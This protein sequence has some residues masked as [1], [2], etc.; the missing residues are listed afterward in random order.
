MSAPGAPSQDDS[1]DV[2]LP[3]YALADW[4]LLQRA[5]TSVWAQ[6]SPAET[7]WVLVNGASPD[8]RQRLAERVFALVPHLIAASGRPPTI[9]VALL[10]Q[11]G[12]TP[13]LNHGLALSQAR[14]LARL[15]AD[16]RMAPE[17]L[18][19][20][21]DHLHRC[22]QA[23]SPVPDVIGSAMEVLDARGDHPTGQ[24]LQR[25]CRDRAIRRYLCVGNPFLH[26]SVML[27]RALLLQVG[28]YRSS[29]GT[30]DLDLWLRLAR[31][32][33]VTFANLPMPL[34]SYTVRSGSL[35]HQRDSFLQSALCR[36]RHCNSPWRVLLF[37]PKIISD[38]MR[39]V[40]A[41]GLWRSH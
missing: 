20:M 16:D 7:L 3:V 26:P 34:T 23:G 28:G 21:R 19:L 5:I 12:I 29:R 32:P 27:R 13:A 41:G 39:F 22:R 30:E 8:D 9:Q 24:L 4:R 15:D 6:D 11:P 35:S 2:L 37:W 25:P 18:R 10:E 17:R 14:W 31:L 36:W 1:I 40:L 38:L 33:G